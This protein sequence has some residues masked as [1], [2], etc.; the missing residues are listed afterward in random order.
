MKI[1]YLSADPGIDIRPDVDL[2]RNRQSRRRG[3]PRLGSGVHTHCDSATS[4]SALQT[5]V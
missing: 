3:R 2:A 1:V 5:G 4:M